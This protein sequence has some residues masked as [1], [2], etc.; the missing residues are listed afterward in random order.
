MAQIDADYYILLNSDVEV[1]PGWIAPIMKVFAEQPD[2]AVCQPKIL[3]FH[4]RERFEYAG[5]SG[6]R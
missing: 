6:G 1:R 3:S 2:V 5:G 4:E